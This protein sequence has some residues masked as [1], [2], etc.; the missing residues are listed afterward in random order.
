MSSLDARVLYDIE[1]GPGEIETMTLYLGQMPSVNSATAALRSAAD[2]VNHRG[3]VNPRAEFRNDKAKLVH[4][5]LVRGD[6]AAVL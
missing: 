3:G 4:V 2:E 1:H 6:A 5:E